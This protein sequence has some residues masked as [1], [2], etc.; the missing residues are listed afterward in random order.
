MFLLDVPSLIPMLFTGATIFAV[1]GIAIAIIVLL[2][3]LVFKRR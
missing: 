2:L 3:M 1:V